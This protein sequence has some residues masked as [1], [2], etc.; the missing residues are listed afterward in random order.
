MICKPNL[1]MKS[2]KKAWK[3]HARMNGLGERFQS[4]YKEYK[5]TETALLKVHNDLMF[6]VDEGKSVIIVLFDLSQAFNTINNELL[7]HRLQTHLEITGNA[8]AWFQSY[9]QNHKQTVTVLSGS[10]TKRDLKYGVPQRYLSVP[11]S[12]LYVHHT[13]WQ[14]HQEIPSLC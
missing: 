6:S 2:A 8:L 5:S 9:L 7:L 11:C 1:R 14:D 12:L 4:A 3:N 13:C 10:S